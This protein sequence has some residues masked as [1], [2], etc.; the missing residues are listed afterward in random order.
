MMM[1]NF[2]KIKTMKLSRLS[3]RKV[4]RNILSLSVI[5]FS[6]SNMGGRSIPILYQQEQTT[7]TP[8]LTLTDTIQ[9]TETVTQQN[10]E[11]ATASATESLTP[12]ISSLVTTE[13]IPTVFLPPTV[14][15]SGDFVSDEVLIRF[16]R[17]TSRLAIDNCIQTAN[18]LIEA[19]ISK[20]TVVRVRIPQGKVAETITTLLACPGIRYAEPNYKAYIADTIPSDPNWNVQYGLINIRA[21]QGWD[22]STGSSSVTIAVVDTGVD[23]GHLDLASKIVPGYDFVNNDA[24]AQDDNGHG[25]HVSGIAAAISNNGLG[26][27]GVSWGAHIMPVKVLNAG[28]NGTFANVAAGIVWATD[29][30]AQ[31]INL[32]L[33]G[34][35]P[36]QVLQDAVNYADSNGVVLV[37]ASGNSGSNFVLYPARYP[38]VIAVGATDSSNAHTGFSNY[39]PQVDLSAP[40][41]SIYSTVIGGY[42]YLSGTSMSAPFV[43]GLAAILRGIPGNSSPGVIALEMESTAL[44]LGAPGID[45][46]YGYGLIQMDAAI[47][48]VLSVPTQTFTPTSPFI[49]ISTTPPISVPGGGFLGRVPPVVFN[50]SSTFIASAPASGFVTVSPTSISTETSQVGITESAEVNALEAPNP[51]PTKESQNWGLPCLGTFLILLGVFLFWLARNDSRSYQRIKRFK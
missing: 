17:R 6:L 25:T 38:Q 1:L 18:A 36:S 7:E 15:I 43:S 47:R 12:T 27:S 5:V 46:V 40:G 49:P 37:A 42:G 26:I 8:S 30:G 32:S 45:D 21:P 39:G 23:F 28:G 33:G 3:G 2:D 29:H 44:D 48:A 50:P 34:S 4:A 22:L 10:I 20:L 9:P 41:T 31:V 35:N 13:S 16:R 14:N 19:E 24:I 51:G 11:T